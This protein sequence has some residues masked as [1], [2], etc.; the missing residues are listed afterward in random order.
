MNKKTLFNRVD[1]IKD[2]VARAEVARAH[3]MIALLGLIC[4]LLLWTLY[5]A[6]DTTPLILAI[7][8]SVLL[9]LIV[10]FSAGVVYSMAKPRK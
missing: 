10:I 7:L 4:I 9:T 3:T 5:F 2:K 6:L 8:A 1:I